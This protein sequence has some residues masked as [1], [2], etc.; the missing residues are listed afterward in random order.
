[1][2]FWKHT[3]FEGHVLKDRYAG[4]YSITRKKF[5]TTAKALT[6]IEA[7]FSWTRTLIRPRL[8]DWNE[9]RS[10]IASIQLSQEDDTFHW[11]LTQSGQFSVKFHHRA[12][13][14]TEVP[15]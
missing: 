7:T 9:L 11:S 4:L 1:M 10:R 5:I 2:I 3:W 6:D 15:I 14:K 13:I 8:A 12:L